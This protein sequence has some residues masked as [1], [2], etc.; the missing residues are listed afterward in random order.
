VVIWLVIC[1]VCSRLWA[2]SK[3]TRQLFLAQSFHLPRQAVVRI[4]LVTCMWTMIESES[5]ISLSEI[6]TANTRATCFVLR[7]KE[8][9]FNHVAPQGP[10]LSSSTYLSSTRMPWQIARRT[11][12]QF[13]VHVA[14]TQ[15]RPQLYH[16]RHGRRKGLVCHRCWAADKNQTHRGG[17]SGLCVPSL[18]RFIF[19]SSMLSSWW[20]LNPPWWSLRF[21]RA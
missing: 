21:V 19:D 15:G 10:R 9:V 4:L 7:Y 3:I 8:L 20:K 18:V 5:W 6:W 16:L 13:S 11:F 2:N 12:L 17:H 14:E 1:S